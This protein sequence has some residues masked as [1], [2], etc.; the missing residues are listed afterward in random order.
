[1]LQQM[2]VQVKTGSFKTS[3][4]HSRELIHCVWTAMLIGFFGLLRKDNI[5]SGKPTCYYC[6]C[7][8]LMTRCSQRLCMF[9]EESG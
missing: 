9:R 2:A 4:G 6:A 3:K 1:M 7:A 5:C 8:P